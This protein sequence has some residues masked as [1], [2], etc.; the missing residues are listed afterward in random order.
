[1]D[2]AV[3]V[4]LGALI[5]A[6]GT[7][8]TALSAARTARVTVRAQGEV[9]KN[10]WLD[11]SRREAYTEFLNAAT[12][13]HGR[14][15]TLSE[16]IKDRS[17]TED[18]IGQSYELWKALQRAFAVVVIVGPEEVAGRAKAVFE[19][20]TSMDNSGASWFAKVRDGDAEAA[21]K[22]LEDFTAAHVKFDVTE[23]A[24][25]SNRALSE[26]HA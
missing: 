18:Q 8:I 23:F 15:W 9:A 12:V 21:E 14:W 2:P 24:S 13:L 25:A 19:T 22:R 16:A 6:G 17:C 5:G 11:D 20:L 3:G 26:A 4:V 1:M 10:R 7:V